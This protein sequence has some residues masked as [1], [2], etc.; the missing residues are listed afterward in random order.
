MNTQ[1][2]IALVNQWPD[3]PNIS[4]FTAKQQV[5]FNAVAQYTPWQDT[6]ECSPNAHPW[7][8]L[9]ELA[10]VTGHKLRLN[11]NSLTAM[12][13]ELNDARYCTEELIASEAATEL[14]LRL[15]LPLSPAFLSWVEVYTLQW[16]DRA[17]PIRYNEVDN[18]V[19]YIARRLDVL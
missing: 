18:A 16:L 15:S 7:I 17:P 10:H 19:D 12:V 9:H 4:P 3:G 13:V 11:R 5:S 2:L 6:L 8:F 1:D 14:C